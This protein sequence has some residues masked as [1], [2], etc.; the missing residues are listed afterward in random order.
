MH[1]GSLATDFV[2][3]NVCLGGF[4][5]HRGGGR[6][7]GGEDLPEVEGQKAL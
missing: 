5:P 1:L 7:E 2:I 3:S 6:W 4:F